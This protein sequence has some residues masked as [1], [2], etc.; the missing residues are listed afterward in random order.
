MTIPLDVLTT[1]SNGGRMIRIA[2][3]VAIMAVVVLTIRFGLV[4]PGALLVVTVLA[5][6]VFAAAVSRADRAR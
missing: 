3:S 1:P 5:L 4:V 2:L 6:C